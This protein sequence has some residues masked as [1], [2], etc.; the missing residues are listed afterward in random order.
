[1]VEVLVVVLIIFIDR[2][3]QP[4]SAQPLAHDGE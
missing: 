4:A 1:M 2:S 3:Y